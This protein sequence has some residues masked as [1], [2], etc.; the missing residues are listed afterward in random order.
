MDNNQAGLG[1]SGFRWELLVS[2]FDDWII[3]IRQIYSSRVG[4]GWFGVAPVEVLMSP[5][6]TMM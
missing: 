5:E 2:R 6:M 3:M 4:R 1:Q